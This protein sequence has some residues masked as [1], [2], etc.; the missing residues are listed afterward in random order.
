MDIKHFLR[1]V[2]ETPYKGV[3]ATKQEMCAYI[4]AHQA[5]QIGKPITL[6]YNAKLGTGILGAE[7]FVPIDKPIPSSKKF[8]YTQ[9]PAIKGC[10]M[11]K[12]KGH[13]LPP[14]AEDEELKQEAL[15]KI[16]EM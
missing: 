7:I 14:Q 6:I 5:S 1:F 15:A 9:N 8:K 4:T 2:G 13:Y 16:A 3:E 10:I 12:Y 11:S